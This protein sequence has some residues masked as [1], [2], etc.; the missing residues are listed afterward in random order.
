MIKWFLALLSAC[1]FS[2]SVWAVPLKLMVF[3]DSLSVGHNLPQEDSFYFQLEKSLQTDGFEV[4]LLN[5]SKSGETSAGGLAK[6]EKALEMQP[7]AVLLE[8]GINDALHG[9][10]VASTQQNL[11]AIIVTFLNKKIPVLLIGMEAPVVM[12]LPYRTAFRQMYQT[13]AQENHLILYPFFMEGLWKNNGIHK[14]LNYF[15]PDLAH[16]SA[17]GVAI[18]TKNIL[19]TVKKFLRSIKR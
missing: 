3:G 17:Q 9:M 10:K 19:P 5:Y 1:I 6:I 14:D 16:P 12:E 15:L 2:T 4:H 11:Q 8:L 18:M 13:L 7:D